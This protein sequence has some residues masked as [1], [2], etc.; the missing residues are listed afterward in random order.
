MMK[1]LIPLAI[2][3]CT[4]FAQANVTYLFTNIS[5]NDPTD[6]AIGENQLFVDVLDEGVGQVRFR[7]RNTGPELSSI[8]DVYFDNGHLLSIASIDNSDPGVSFSQGASPPN[9][10][11]ANNATP[12]FQVTPGL[13]ADSDPAVQPNG[14]N[15]GESLGIVMNLQVGATFDDILNDLQ[16]GALRVGIHVQGYESGGSESYVSNGIIPAPSAILLGGIGT[17]L[18]GWLRRRKA[19]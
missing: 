15:P 6:A 19:S 14:V 1:K 4:V 18:V 7:F 13:L 11:A 5:N 16:T 17:G 12:S 2:L 10:P 8:T 9:L 3:F